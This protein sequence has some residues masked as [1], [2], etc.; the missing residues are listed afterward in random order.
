MATTDNFAFEKSQQV[1]GVSKYTP[2]TEKSFNYLPDINNGV[3]SNNSGL[4][5][6][7]FDLS[8]IYNSSLYTDAG[9]LYITIPIVTVA[10]S[11]SATTAQ[12]A[13]TAGYAL[14]TPKNGYH[15][16]V[17]QI[18]IQAG[19]KI[20]ADSQPFVNVARNFKLLSQ[21]TK[22]DLTNM[23]ASLGMADCLDSPLSAYFATTAGVTTAQPGV[24]YCNNQ[25][26]AG[27]TT[28]SQGYQT[29][30][31][32]SQFASVSNDALQKRISR[33]TSVSNGGTQNIYASSQ[34]A[35]GSQPFIA[36]ATTLTNEFRPYYTV[37]ASGTGVASSRMTW[38]DVAILP[39]K[40]LTDVM[41]KI[42]LTK[43]LDAQ[44]R[45]YV[46]TGVVGIPVAGP[47]SGTALQYGVPS[48]S[49]F[50][51]TCPFTVNHI[52]ATS[53]NGGLVAGVTAIVAG[54]FV[55]KSPTTSVTIPTNL[56]TAVSLSGATHPM[57]SCRA[58]YSQIKLDAALDIKYLTENVSKELVWES[59]IFNQY[60]NITS[61][62]TFSQLV[63]SGIKN[64][65]GV[66]IC[67]FISGATPTT[68]LGATPL[69]IFQYG[70]PYDTAPASGAPTYDDVIWP[71]RG[72]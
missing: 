69:S 58:Y 25:P 65:I 21:L 37:S 17:H 20:V 13:P 49:T 6:V 68:V 35:S 26:F 16:L 22:Q 30:M 72:K 9:D 59:Y 62:N 60:S 70:S 28:P 7:Q 1:Q 40:Y 53:A 23:G 54:I 12:T 66:L 56:T 10:E 50:A 45:M 47:N 48:S 2:Y 38:Y 34:A 18:E 3:Y 46:N 32:S 29:A 41:D 42:G 55:Q 43:K 5:L 8:S 63:Q 71:E 39:L 51:N 44:V 31:S 36:T 57:P 19:G 67:P 52:P 14:C 4:T 64:P 27:G 61:S 11:W 15:H 24:G 33:Y